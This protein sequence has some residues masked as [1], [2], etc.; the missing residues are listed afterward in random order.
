MTAHTRPAHV[1]NKQNSTSYE[2]IWTKVSPINKK[3]FVSNT[4]WQREN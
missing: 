4:F 2:G 3:L 1:Q